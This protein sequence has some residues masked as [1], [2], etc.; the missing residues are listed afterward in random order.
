MPKGL[1]GRIDNMGYQ[2]FIAK[3]WLELT[4]EVFYYM[5]YA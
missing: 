2:L 5:M 4:Y 1:L 3:V